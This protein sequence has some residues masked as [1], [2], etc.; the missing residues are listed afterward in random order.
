M[1]KKALKMKRS[2]IL[3]DNQLKLGLR[4]TLFRGR[5]NGKTRFTYALMEWAM[6]P[7]Q[8]QVR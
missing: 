3:R 7:L 6:G 8:R 5:K 2:R 1:V 4:A